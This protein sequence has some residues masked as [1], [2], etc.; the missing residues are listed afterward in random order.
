MADLEW[1]DG[2][3]CCHDCAT[4]LDHY[5]AYYIQGEPGFYCFADQQRRAGEL[6]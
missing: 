4:P 2:A 3:W 5:D 1:L 6:A